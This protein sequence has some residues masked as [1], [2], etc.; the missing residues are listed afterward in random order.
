MNL[1]EQTVLVTGANRGLG[2]SFVDS[3]VEAGVRKVY[4]TARNVDQLSFLKSAYGDKI[5]LLTLDITDT[6]QIDVAARS[7]SDVTLLL[8]NA[9]V[10]DFAKPLETD[11]RILNRNM[12]TNFEGTYNMTTRFADVIAANGGG[13]I[14]NVL[15]FLCFVSAPLFA[16]YN[17]S[18]AASWSMAM[19]LRPY[20]RE[21]GVE[22]SNVFPT[23]IDT[24]MLAALDKDKDTPEDVARSILEGVVAEQEDI[25]PCGA[26]ATFDRWRED[27][28]A[29]EMAFSKIA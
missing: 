19:S 18:K 1:E 15:T 21:R 17:A 20:L 6:Q 2:R 8:N 9:G 26:R 12:T 23:S 24:D 11:A 22:I 10:L 28:K 7:A 14:V 16:A 13:R 4:A 29:V 27:Y 5:E 3:L 25:F